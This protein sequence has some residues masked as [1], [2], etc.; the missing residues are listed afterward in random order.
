MF[1]SKES[2]PTPL[3]HI[4]RNVLELDKQQLAHLEAAL[5][6]TWGSD[7]D[8]VDLVSFSPN[9][10]KELVHIQQLPNGFT[11]RLHVANNVLR[12]ISAFQLFTT[13]L[14]RIGKHPGRDHDAWR[15]ITAA[16]FRKWEPIHSDIMLIAQWDHLPD[17]EEEDPIPPSTRTQGPGSPVSV[18]AFPAP[19][20]TEPASPASPLPAPLQ[21][22]PAHGESSQHDSIASAELDEASNASFVDPPPTPA[23]G[24]PAGIASPRR[25]TEPV[26]PVSPLPAPLPE[27]TAHGENPEES[28]T[29]SAALDDTSLPSLE[30]CPASPLPGSPVQIAIK[31]TAP[32]VPQSI[33]APLDDGLAHVLQELFELESDSPLER[34]L[35]KEEFDV[36]DSLLLLQGPSLQQ[37][38]FI[39]SDG[40]KQPLDARSIALVQALQSFVAHQ[41]ATHAPLRPADFACIPKDDFDA[42]ICSPAFAAT[43]AGRVLL[44]PSRTEAPSVSNEPTV[45]RISPRVT[46]REIA[47]LFDADDEAPTAPSRSEIDSFCGRTLATFQLWEDCIALTDIQPKP[48]LESDFLQDLI[49]FIG[50]PFFLQVNSKPL[51]DAP[52]SS[53]LNVNGKDDA[54]LPLV[55]ESSGSTVAPL[56][57]GQAPVLPTVDPPVVEQPVQIVP[58]PLPPPDPDPSSHPPTPSMTMMFHPH[59]DKLVGSRDL[60]CDLWCNLSHDDHC[61]QPSDDCIQPQDNCR[62]SS[63]T[64]NSCCFSNSPLAS[65]S[66]T[67]SSSDNSQNLDSFVDCFQSSSFHPVKLFQEE[68]P[69]FTPLLLP[70]SKAPVES[71]VQSPVDPMNGESPDQEES[72]LLCPSSSSVVQLTPSL[73]VPSIEEPVNGETPVPASPDSMSLQPKLR[74]FLKS[75]HLHNKQLQSTFQCTTDD[76]PPVQSRAASN[77]STD[78]IT[79]LLFHDDILAFVEKDRDNPFSPSLPSAFHCFTRSPT[80]NPV[81]SLEHPLSCPKSIFGE[82]P[83]KSPTASLFNPTSTPRTSASTVPSVASQLEHR[84]SQHSIDSSIHGEPLLVSHSNS[85]VLIE[86]SAAAAALCDRSKQVPIHLASKLHVFKELHLPDKDRDNPVFCQ[87]H[88]I[89][90]L[91]DFRTGKSIDEERS[92]F[93]PPSIADHFETSLAQVC[94]EI[95]CV[96]PCHSPKRIPKQQV[97]L[98]QMADNQDK[99]KSFCNSPRFK[100]ASSDDPVLQQDDIQDWNDLS[101]TEPQLM[102]LFHH[103]SMNSLLIC[104]FNCLITCFNWNLICHFLN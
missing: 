42:F 70:D 50:T 57:L 46:Q 67:V 58:Q 9:T 34:A 85:R 40:S 60:L 86:P 13:H 101:P 30:E 31:P 74:M 45:P 88:C 3:Q 26:P 99:L 52:L 71:P 100:I 33:D 69:P 53:E 89:I 87:P 75:F 94:E 8:H 44:N 41:A 72:P 6:H 18:S 59:H 95:H 51:T 93:T 19:A 81:P 14:H 64:S 32:S 54:P 61:N 24:F 4:L 7:T 49:S 66:S 39:D 55:K 65:D 79:D 27:T 56:L 97:A 29:S 96:L 48:L 36:A 78:A 104:F 90:S 35:L 21:G 82:S 28:S 11:R 20:E 23:P 83:S 37:L 10:L 15:S 98:L 80:D 62:S 92:F 5:D 76:Q 22:T 77:C 17:P 102:P 16:D 103:R 68:S 12:K 38:R 43:E 73:L 47:K 91:D 25:K 2:A 63:P 1:S 84:L